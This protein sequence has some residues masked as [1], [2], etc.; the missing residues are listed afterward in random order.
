MSEIFRN[1]QILQYIKALGIVL[2]FLG[3]GYIFEKILLGRLKKLAKKTTWEGDDIIIEALNKW[4]TYTI[5]LLG[6]YLAILYLPLSEKTENNI[7]RLLLVLALFFG[8]IILSKIAV[9]FVGLYTKNAD[10]QT[11]STSIFSNITKVIVFG[12]GGL[13][14]LQSLGVSITPILTA[15][16]VGGLAVALALQDTLSNLFSGVQVLASGQIK[17]GNYIKIGS[18]EEGYVIDITWRNTTLKALPNN[19]IVIPNSKI[20]QSTIINFDGPTKEMALAVPFTV[21]YGTDLEKVKKAVL[22]TG[23]Y[24]MK[25]IPGG[26]PGHE[27]VLR[28]TALGNYGLEFTAALKV[29]EF[30]EQYAIKHEFLERLYRRFMEYGIKIPY[31]TQTVLL[32]KD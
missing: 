18:G 30:S 13:V 15:L 24:V 28:M 7:T 1:E 6:I 20:A 32:G 3:I 10:G 23:S 31:P 25:N 26:V 14:I 29:K 12:L 2:G 5:L 8:T 17:P 16:G 4:L 27:T 21:A 19:L 11:P 9:G 22:E